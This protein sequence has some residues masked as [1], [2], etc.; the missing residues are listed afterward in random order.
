MARPTNRYAR[1]QARARY[2]KPKR[3]GSSLAWNVAIGVIV[4]L[5]VGGVILS[6]AGGADPPRPNKDHWHAS[7][8]VNR[9]GE[10][11]GPAPSFEQDAENPNIT[12]GLHSHADGLIHIHPHASNEAGNNATLGRFVDYGG[13]DLS[14]D[15]F[16]L[17]E[18][19][20]AE[21]GQTCTAGEGGAEQRAELRWFVNGDE[22]D[23]NP[24]DYQPQDGDKIVLSFNAEGTKLEDLGEA[25]NQARLPN[26]VDVTGGAPPSS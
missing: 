12:A 24:A 6:R 10:W 1:A 23:G 2:R 15:S 22:K 3:R 4:V 11:L 16:Q 18:G 5:G 7:L 8:D 9:C 17:W 14:E 21:D 26:P 20:P 25:P 19:E 13:W